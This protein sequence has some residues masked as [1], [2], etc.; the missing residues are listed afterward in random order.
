MPLSAQREDRWR[1]TDPYIE[2]LWS[3]RLGPKATLLARRPSEGGCVA[4]ERLAAESEV[5]RPVRAVPGAEGRG[6]SAVGS[7]G[8]FGLAACVVKAGR[9]RSGRRSGR[10]AS[11]DRVSSEVGSVRSCVRVVGGHTPLQV[12]LRETCGAVPAGAGAAFRELAGVVERKAFQRVLE[13]RHPTTGERLL[14]A[15][16]RHGVVISRSA[17]PLCSMSTAMRCTRSTTRRS[18]WA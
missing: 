4:H 8:S 15:R 3:D 1:L 12:S 17:P 10:S 18:C 13:C 11:P 14:A 5:W 2:R 7:S 6:Q 9:V 16:D